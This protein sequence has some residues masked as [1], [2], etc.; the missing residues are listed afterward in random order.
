MAH[1]L[2]AEAAQMPDAAVGFIRRYVGY[3]QTPAHLIPLRDEVRKN[4]KAKLNAVFHALN[5]RFKQPNAQWFGAF[6]AAAE[7]AVMVEVA[8]DALPLGDRRVLRDLWENLLRA[9]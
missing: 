5:E 1:N 8:G 6:Q 2:V 7:M 3:V 9:R 4:H